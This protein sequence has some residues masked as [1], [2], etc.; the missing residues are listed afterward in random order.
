M[1]GTLPKG[2]FSCFVTGTDTE[3]GKTLVS[4]ALL[5]ILAKRGV[6]VA[7]MKPIA[8]GAQW[9]DGAWHN[10]DADMLA[11][12]VNVPMLQALTTPYMLQTPAAPHI[13]AA[14]DKVTIDPSHIQA[15]FHEV[16]S[17]A[18]AVVVEGVGGFRVPLTDSYDTSDMAQQLGLPV[19]LVVGLRLGCIS[20]ALLT[21]EAIQAR[22]LTLVGWVA[23]MVDPDMSYVDANI[24][25]LAKRINAPMLGNI[26][27]LTTPSAAQAASFIYD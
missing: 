2:A 20:Q 11:A 9:R 17:K 27:R 21:V 10:D 16:K 25:A 24:Q 6:R 12:E 7:A 18:Q 1:I 5:H 14:I 13:A 23:N 15:C 26:P 8:A 22:G 3:I 19:I 4:A